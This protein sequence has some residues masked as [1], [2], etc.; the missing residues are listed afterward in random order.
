MAN[1]SYQDEDWIFYVDV[2]ENRLNSLT[3]ENIKTKSKG[4][5]HSIDF[6]LQHLHLRLDAD[7]NYATVDCELKF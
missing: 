5:T 7:G 1:I 2:I 6:N 3:L 4:S